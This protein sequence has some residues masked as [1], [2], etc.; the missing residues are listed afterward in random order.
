MRR[1]CFHHDGRQLLTVGAD[2]A[3]RIWNTTDGSLHQTIRWPESDANWMAVSPDL[4]TALAACGQPEAWKMVLRDVQS[5][6][7]LRE[8]P[9]TN[10][11]IRAA[12]FSPDGSRVALIGADGCGGIWDSRTGERVAG[13]FPHGGTLT[14][15]DWSPDGRRVLTAGTSPEV[16]VWDAAT[17]DPALPPLRMRIRPV[18]LARFSADGRFIV[19]R[20]DE[21]LVRVWDAGTG[22]AI[23][24]FLHHRDTVRDVFITAD[25]QLVTAENMSEIRVR[26]LSET[27]GSAVDVR[28]YARLLAGWVVESPGSLAPAA[29]RELTTLLHSLHDRQPAWFVSTPEQRLD[30]HRVMATKTTR[31]MR[32]PPPCSTSNASPG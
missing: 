27:T 18:E 3:N 20:C 11:D 32:C 15:L 21:D 6:A 14:W 16:K 24:P 2:R 10:P 7:T 22:E 19:A 8:L 13:A 1:A 9:G 17:G 30:W 12:A 31:W 29:P 23:T 25:R 28:D 4:R 5:G 26:T